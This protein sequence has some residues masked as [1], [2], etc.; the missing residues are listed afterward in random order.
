MRPLVLI[1]AAGFGVRAGRPEAKEMLERRAGEP[2]INWPLQLAQDRGWSAHVITRR[3]KKSLINHIEDLRARSAAE[4]HIQLVEPT[5]D[6]PQTLL[7]SEPYWHN[8][9]LVLLPDVEFYPVEVLDTL[10]AHMSPQWDVLWA[11]HL[12]SNLSS[13]GTFERKSDDQVALCEKPKP[14]RSGWA[15]GVYAFHRSVGKMILET[16]CRSTV[17]HIRRNLQLKGKGF[18][19]ETFVDLT[20]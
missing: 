13:W 3:E 2:L 15:W 8:W 18:R 4:I 10:A 19:L 14:K 17:D 5:R 11:E 1:P 12:Q 9:N 7:Q 6:W 20:R 16:Q